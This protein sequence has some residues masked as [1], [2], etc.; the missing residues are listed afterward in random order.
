MAIDAKFERD[1]LY[2]ARVPLTILL[3][4]LAVIDQLAAK[5]M[6]MR[7]NLRW[8]SLAFFV[9]ALILTFIVVFISFPLYLIAIG[10]FIYSFFHGGGIVGKRTRTKEVRDVA[11][12]L[13]EDTSPVQEFAVRM[14]LKGN[15]VLLKQ[16]AWPVRKK[17]QQKSFQDDWLSIEGRLLDRSEFKYSITD[18]IRQRT[19]VNA[20]SKTKTKTRTLHLISLQLS[21]PH[22]RYGDA[23]SVTQG[24][25][26]IKVP[27]SAHLKRVRITEGAIGLKALASNES[28]IKETS[29]A[30]FLGAYRILNFSRRAAA[31]AGSGA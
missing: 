14:N 2:Q 5:T 12:L 29:A 1:L 23:R 17:G 27:S 19:F 30:L 28:V 9:L 31:A 18:L 6:A 16:E 10:L 4:D 24:A 20:N 11:A 21:Y 25:G 26:A 13:R 15:E 3:N 7:T 22:S 8:A